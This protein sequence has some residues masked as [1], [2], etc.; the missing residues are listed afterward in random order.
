MEA[1]VDKHLPNF[2]QDPTESSVTTLLHRHASEF[3]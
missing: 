2:R 3:F 1:L